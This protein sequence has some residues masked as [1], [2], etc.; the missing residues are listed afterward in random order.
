MKEDFFDDGLWRNAIIIKQ[1][2]CICDVS[3]SVIIHFYRLWMMLV[4]WE[5]FQSGIHRALPQDPDLIGT[6]NIREPSE[7][8]DFYLWSLTIRPREGQSATQTKE[9]NKIYWK[10]D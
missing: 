2:N 1:E 9:I 5:F 6:N 8:P 7:I 4:E 10:K 3:F